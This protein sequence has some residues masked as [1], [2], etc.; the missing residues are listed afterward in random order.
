MTDDRFK[1]IRL[2]AD[3][4]IVRYRD[5]ALSAD[6]GEP[7]FVGSSGLKVIAMS[8]DAQTCRRI[9]CPETGCRDRDP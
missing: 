7:L 9:G 2:V 4:G 8:F 1:L 3:P 6:N 5:P